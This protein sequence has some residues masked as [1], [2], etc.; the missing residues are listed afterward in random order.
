MWIPEGDTASNVNVAGV[1]KILAA[2]NP[3]VAV[4][5]EN[6]RASASALSRYGLDSPRLVLAID[7]G[8][9]GS[10]RRNILVGAPTAGGNYATVGSADAIFVIS[11]SAVNALMSQ[12]LSK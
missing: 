3:L 2:I 1:K 11:H 9:E 7:R 8:D 12:L 6:L 4:R 5:V 10:V